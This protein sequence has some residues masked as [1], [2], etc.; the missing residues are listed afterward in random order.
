[1]ETAVELVDALKSG[2]VKASELVERCLERIRLL[3]AKI[4]AFVTLNP[5]ALEEVKKCQGK[6]LA[7]LPIAVKDNTLTKGLRTTFGSKLFENFVPSEDSVIVKRLR[8]AGAV[9]IGKTNMTEFGLIAYTDNVLFGPT[10]NPWDLK[11]TVG[12]SSGGSAAAVAAGMVPVAT[13]MMP[14]V[15]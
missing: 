7:G 1:V 12:G 4:N 13:G 3:N 8:R 11:R 14:A 6:P 2:K 5:K 15:A 10:R 9:I